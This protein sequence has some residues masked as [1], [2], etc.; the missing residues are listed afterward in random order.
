VTRAPPRKRFGQHF[1]HDR[2]VIERLVAAIDPRPDETLVEIGPGR[3]ALTLPLL[4]R[5]GTL[6]A[7]E[8][9]RDLAARLPALSASHGRLALH[10]ADAVEFDFA[11]LA[12]AQKL[13]IV[14]NLPY[15]VS[16]P[17]LFHLIEHIDS[18]ADITVMLQK[19]VA[20]RMAARAGTDDYGRLSV[21]MQWRFEV[22]PLFEVGPG[23]FV[24]APKVRSRVVRLRPHRS[25]PATVSDPEFFE[26]MVKAAFN[27]RRKTLR[28]S[29]RGVVDALA[30]AKSGIDAGRRA[31]TLTLEE[32]ARL[33]ESVAMR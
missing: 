3:G 4:D 23:A 17:L 21:M 28:N 18:I 16:T 2:A 1:L 11:T 10:V 12:R 20:D 9:D 22:E 14:G 6:H 27:Q 5:S 31:E 19:E 32:Y 33:A 30:F 24:P 13:R 8:I 7:I 25:S 15:N 26:R 29:L